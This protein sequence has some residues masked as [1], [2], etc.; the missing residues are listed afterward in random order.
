MLSFVRAAQLVVWAEPALEP[1][2]SRWEE[3]RRCLHGAEEQE[4]FLP[5]PV[6]P[7]QVLLMLSCTPWGALAALLCV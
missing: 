2:F 3:G 5:I 4:I 1:W 7:L 6:L